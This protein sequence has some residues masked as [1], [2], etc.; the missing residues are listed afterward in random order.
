[1]SIYGVLAPFMNVYVYS[2]LYI[3]QRRING[4]II[5]SLSPNSVLGSPGMICMI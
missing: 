3:E 4:C 1:M 2:Y 5:Y